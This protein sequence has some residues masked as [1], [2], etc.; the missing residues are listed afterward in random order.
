MSGLEKITQFLHYLN[1]LGVE[2]PISAPSSLPCI[3]VSNSNRSISQEDFRATK[4]TRRQ[5]VALREEA[6]AKQNLAATR[7]QSLVTDIQL[8]PAQGLLPPESGFH[9]L[10]TPRAQAIKAAAELLSWNVGRI[11]A[12]SVA[13]CGHEMAPPQPL[14]A[15]ASHQGFAVL[16]AI[17]R[18]LSGLFSQLLPWHQASAAQTSRRITTT[19]QPAVAEQQ[20][21]A[22]RIHSRGDNSTR[23]RQQ[24]TEF[25][26]RMAWGLDEQ[27]Q[28]QVIANLTDQDIVFLY[29][30]LQTAEFNRSERAHEEMIRER[31]V[32][33]EMSLKDKTVAADSL[34]ARIAGW[35]KER[36]QKSYTLFKQG[37]QSY[38]PLHFLA[39]GGEAL[40]GYF[41]TTLGEV[42]SGT[43]LD[44]EPGEREVDRLLRLSM[45]VV[46][47][48]PLSGK[49][50]NV[51]LTRP[52]SAAGGKPLAQ[53][54][55]TVISHPPSGMTLHSVLQKEIN[56]QRWQ[57][58]PQGENSGVAQ[59]AGI[60]PVIS[61]PASRNPQNNLWRIEHLG[62]EHSFSHNQ[63]PEWFIK[64]ANGYQP[65]KLSAED[66]TCHLPGG[67]KIYFSELSQQWK[68]F[69]PGNN[70]LHARVVSS[71]PEILIRTAPGEQ[72]V[73]ASVGGP[74]RKVWYSALADRQ[75]LEIRS[76]GASETNVEIGYLEGRMEGDFFSVSA[77]ESQPVYHQRV[78][79]WQPK[80]Q[81]WDT[82]TSPFALLKSAEGKIDRSWLQKILNPPQDL[83]ALHQRP[84][85][86]RIGRD[87]FLRW[88]TQAN[89]EARY[90][91]LLPTGDGSQYRT[92]QPAAE[93]EVYFRYDETSA[94]WH[95][96]PFT[97][98]AFAGLPPQ[99]RVQLTQPFS[100]DYAVPGY[101]NLYLSGNDLWI[102]TGAD[103]HGVAEYIRVQQD[104]IDGDLF[105]LR[106][107]DSSGPDTL[108]LF[109]YDE[110][111]EF[112]LEDKQL[113]QPRGK[114]A[115][116]DECA[117]P[118]G[119]SRQSVADTREPA[120]KK[121]RSEEENDEQDQAWL[122][123]QP[124]LLLEMVRE[125]DSAVTR[126]KKNLAY[127]LRLSLRAPKTMPLGAIARYAGID[128]RRLRSWL[129]KTTPEAHRWFV[130]HPKTDTE[131]DMSYALRLCRL[132]PEG[133]A[134]TAIAQHT[135]V[136][137]NSIRI[138]L[139]RFSSDE[140]HWFSLYPRRENESNMEYAMRLC[141][142]PE[143]GATLS[144]I[145]DH[146]GVSEN[147]LRTSL[148]R[149][150]P[151][152]QQ[153]LQTHPQ[154][155][156]EAAM[157]YAVRLALL[158]H[159]GITY[160]AIAIHAGV[161]EKSLR[162]RINRLP[163]D[164]Q[165][166]LKSHPPGENEDAMD[167]A[168]RLYQMPHEK[169]TITTI[170]VRAG[171]DESA[172]LNRLDASLLDKLA[173]ASE[174]QWLSSYPRLFRE[175]NI[176]YAVR[177]TQLRD[178]QVMAGSL[179]KKQVKN[180]TIA[181]HARVSPQFLS[182]NIARTKNSRQW[183]NNY[184]RL[185][186]EQLADADDFIA[187]AE[188]NR[189]YALRLVKMRNQQ[190]QELTIRKSEI[191]RHVG[192]SDNQ[193]NEGLGNEKIDWLRG[194]P[195]LSAEVV[196]ENESELIIQHKN[197][198]YARRLADRRAQEQMDWLLTDKNL[199]THAGIT[200]DSFKQAQD[201]QF[202]G[203]KPQFAQSAELEALQPTHG[204]LHLQLKQNPPLLTD[205]L[206][207][208]RSVTNEVIRGP[209]FISDIHNIVKVLPKEQREE[210]AHRFAGLAQEV[211]DS[212]GSRQ[213]FFIDEQG[214]RQP[215]ALSEYLEIYYDEKNWAVGLQLKAKKTIPP[216]TF[217]GVYTGT[218]HKD[219]S[220]LRAEYK[221][222]GSQAVLTYLWGVK[223]GP[224]TV[225]GLQNANILALMNTD[226]MHGLPVQG[227]NKVSVGYINDEI[228]F[229][230]TT[231]EIAQGEQALISYG[232]TYQPD[233]LIQTSL[234]NDIV[235]IIAAEE[236][237]Y[238]VIKDISG[239]IAHI[240]G[241]KGEVE[242]VPG[243]AER[244]TLKE[245]L[246]SRGIVRYDALSKKAAK[247]VAISKDD[248]NNLYHAMAKA[249]K[250]L[251]GRDIIEEKIKAMK[252]AV[253]AE[254]AAEEGVV[255]PEPPAENIPTA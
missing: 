78:L 151:R 206:N 223:K 71:L 25:L 2:T 213:D 227:E 167:Y 149:L 170:A 192:I 18:A 56:G 216:F 187:A 79:K 102:H 254:Y 113:C 121:P 173:S 229:Y 234:N 172:L 59:P 217:L 163:P 7:W 101:H 42:V 3:E 94:Q 164:V 162:S 171:V 243:N 27:Q 137:E 38:N 245:R 41:S 165:R 160:T 1:N 247:R 252:D 233:Y 23:F 77:R 181:R 180:A 90:L 155:E 104:A 92:P 109:R 39:S 124:R 85:L 158:P 67:D 9:P 255:K 207:P 200:M 97:H 135:G 43:L 84:G 231:A 186:G 120:G 240:Y 60:Q 54:P 178:E 8:L 17:D 81:R 103:R 98:E 215:G 5:R 190:Q 236:K 194:V 49:T 241:P 221:K 74:E 70:H 11:T 118:S 159:E 251:G 156:N 147:S 208:A 82:A 188:K 197:Q 15:T 148:R 123:D 132:A 115:D 201:P 22:Y 224:A 142:L 230:Y 146:T 122:D 253:A 150:T 35:G 134:I 179:V 250:P 88:E 204:L 246:D 117:G 196:L 161:N 95:F 157:A 21:P 222:M 40:L 46:M 169:V 73:L 61:Y 51:M 219:A 152:A 24:V 189:R 33:Y 108:W 100:A 226:K 176:E 211:V 20:L 48:E 66:G 14:P 64:F 203:T 198:F 139:K 249:I 248:E 69:Y 89:G 91:E 154:Y 141:Q 242:A 143:E 80:T 125:R 6:R 127:A 166:W 128:V 58:F 106:V 93:G 116:D 212:D 237:C 12:G 4:G 16:Q 52:A 220:S 145:A 76:P 238:F 133:V 53:L 119:I 31:T 47:V 129:N 182:M 26:D 105:S 10:S 30:P 126:S 131:S 45:N 209:V 183:L 239:N 65:V 140:V 34:G 191:A 62:G 112:V 44:R 75:Y 175:S 244:Y 107:P 111:D 232:D 214:N 50:F 55:G 68:R 63:Q 205:P 99:V 199:A 87:H 110:D 19:R 235:R 174:K 195:R 32:L 136:R 37:T 114:R 210:V 83:I 193:L 168:V 184:P 29:P 225:S 138:W 57:L 144:A 202:D 13:D 177:L 96:L 228:P 28:Q 218:R 130:S 86:Y 153:W 185:P 72:G 36:T